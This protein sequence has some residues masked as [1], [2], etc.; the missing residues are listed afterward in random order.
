M[1]TG[2]ALDGKPYA[3]NPH[4][5]FDE[6]EV[7]LAATPRRGSLLYKNIIAH[8]VESKTLTCLAAAFAALATTVT[9]TANAA[10]TTAWAAVTGEWTFDYG[11]PLA[12]KTG[13]AL[14]KFTRTGA[15]NFTEGT[16]GIATGDGWLRAGQNNML[17]CYHGL[18]ANSDYT[19]VM[20]VRVPNNENAFQEWHALLWAKE[21]H[22]DGDIWLKVDG[23][24]IKL[25]MAG[26][27]RSSN[28]FN[29]GIEFDQWVRVVIA[30][31]SG[32]KRCFYVNGSLKREAAVQV[33]NMEAT[34]NG[35]FYLLGDN[36]GED[37]DVDISY[38]AIYDKAMSADEISL[39]HSQPL[40]AVA[41]QRPVPVARWNFNNYDSSNPRATGILA[42]T[43]G[44][45]AKPC[46]NENEAPSTVTSDLG[47]I[48]VVSDGL[49]AGNY[50]L[51]IPKSSSVAL[52][53][54]DAVKNHEWTMNI[55]FYV[56]QSGVFHSF[57][58]RD[59][60]SG[61]GDLFLTRS[62]SGRTT[63]GIGGGQFAGS[64]SYQVAPAIGE[65]QTMTLSVGASHWEITL[66]GS[67]YATSAD[68]DMRGYFADSNEPLTVFDGVGHLLLCGD[69]DGDD[70]LMYIDYVELFDSAS[71]MSTKAWT[72]AAGNGRLNDAGN[73][74]GGVVPVAG[75]TLDFSTITT[76]T[77]LNADFGD[78]REFAAAVFGP[79]L[80]TLTG[81]LRL[82]TLRN[83]HTLAVASGATLAV[84]GDLVGYAANNT[85]PLLYSNEGTVTV[86]GK[87]QFRSSGARS[88]DSVVSQYAV[89]TANTT[90][91]IANG[92]AYNA[93][94]WSDWL[95]A[96][97]G[98][99]GGGAGKWVVG[100]AGLTIPRTRQINRGGF[101]VLGQDVTLGSSADWTLAESYRH[102]GTDLYIRNDGKVTV[103]T[104]DYAD[105]TV[106]RIVTFKGFINEDSSL[107]T[108]LSVVGCGTLVIDTATV[109]GKT[110]IVNSTLAVADGATLQVNA[111]KAITGTGSISLAA[112][113]T[114]ALPANGDGAFTT[115]DIIPVTLPAE[116][117]ATVKIDGEKL[118]KNVE[119]VLLNSAPTGYAGHL[120]VTGTALDGRKYRL[121][122]QNG[123]LVL[124]IWTG[125]MAVI[126]R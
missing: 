70:N 38:A 65:W 32:S 109:E 49:E 118:E 107:D 100:A 21:S 25:R 74:L 46:H 9:L 88:A 22:N 54:P 47:D 91:I 12:A 55:R 69:G 33:D 123:A 52:P 5:R 110:N 81:N 56:P 51:A 2:K 86:G 14:E 31:T 76:P 73:W 80:A 11:S 116:G 28:V 125:G 115:P 26:D 3:G 4:V 90:P 83:A 113:A 68:E 117:T 30:Y 108:A 114:L 63:D 57:F 42:A 101:R 89:V 60:S 7:A 112:G 48:S 59:T 94:S 29:T 96:S 62:R 111:G 79:G 10:T 58:D 67:T 121:K 102:Y 64:N 61:D 40:A 45:D 44:G 17:K 41:A 122:R 84:S 18:P 36:D 43:I 13:T 20:D 19:I 97:L 103:D 105:S 15:E 77:T 39:L 35:Y 85:K 124:S 126:I 95:V 27:G 24:A 92:L 8:I 120:T 71:A 98:S 37:Y 99:M 82:A 34:E 23:G 87:V 1:T 50:A 106:P 6:G 119:Y 72:G 66:N 53:I 93:D 75:D 104:S 78:S 16:D